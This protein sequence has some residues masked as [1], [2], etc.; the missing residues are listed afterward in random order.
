M[1]L[2][3]PLGFTLPEV[4]LALSVLSVTSVGSAHL[5]T[6]TLHAWQ[7]LSPLYQGEAELAEWLVHL[8][9]QTPL[10]GQFSSGREWRITHEVEGIRWF[11]MA[12]PAF[13]EWLPAESGWQ[14]R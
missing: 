4:M 11:V 6:H 5:L 13:P 1:V 7:Q 2:K 10:T 3:K 12:H 8:S 9:Q 14:V